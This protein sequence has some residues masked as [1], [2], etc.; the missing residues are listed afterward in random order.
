MD[1][2]VIGWRIIYG[3]GSVYSSDDGT[4]D[5]A[6]SNDVQILEYLHEPPYRTFTYAEDEYQL[7]PEHSKKF[8]AWMEEGAFYALVAAAFGGLL[9]LTYRG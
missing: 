6:P 8:G 2:P 9:T 4:W 3:D 7:T 5:D 1:L